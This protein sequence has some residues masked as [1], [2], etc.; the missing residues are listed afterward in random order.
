VSPPRPEPAK[1]REQ[2]LHEAGLAD[3]VEELADA[4]RELLKR[5]PEPLSQHRMQ[6]ALSAWR[7]AG[8]VVE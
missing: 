5:G 8:S 7:E 3:L 6:K 2:E 4:A 1:K